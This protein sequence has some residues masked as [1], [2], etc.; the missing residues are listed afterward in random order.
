MYIHTINYKKDKCMYMDKLES[1]RPLASYVSPGYGGHDV[2]EGYEERWMGSKQ[3]IY[4]HNKLRVRYMYVYI[5]KSSSVLDYLRPMLGEEMEFIVSLRGMKRQR[6][7]I[8][9]ST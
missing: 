5:M 8:N 7:A 6:W 9:S 3:Y 2:M 1:I 4:T